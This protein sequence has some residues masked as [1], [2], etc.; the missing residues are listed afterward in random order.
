MI[1]NFIFLSN[2]RIQIRLA[3]R[4]VPAESFPKPGYSQAD[5]DEELKAVQECIGRQDLI[6]SKCG[7]PMTVIPNKTYIRNLINNEKE[8]YDPQKL[9]ISVFKL[10]CS[11]RGGKE[12]G[13]GQTSYHAFLPSWICPSLPYSYAF[14]DQV[15]QYFHNEAN[16]QYA[17][18]ARYFG[19][20]RNVVKSIV[21]LL[22]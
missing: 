14:I 2:D 12:G 17:T 18:T 21:R 22:Q 16:R 11:C 13:N 19:I 7:K 5:Y 8:Y 15:L 1:Q 20:T 4:D 9:K 6:C 10:H 3:S